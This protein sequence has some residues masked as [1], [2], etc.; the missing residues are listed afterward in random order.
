MK[1]YIL[2]VGF[3]IASQYAQAQTLK[4]IFNTYQPTSTTQANTDTPASSGG[5]QTAPLDLEPSPDPQA[6][7]EVDQTP[8]PEK[9]ATIEDMIAALS[10]DEDYLDVPNG[11]KK[12]LG[13][14]LPPIIMSSNPIYE[15]I[16]DILVAGGLGANKI[17]RWL[18]T[19]RIEGYKEFFRIHGSTSVAKG[20]E[21]GEKV[22]DFLN[23]ISDKEKL[24]KQNKVDAS[25]QA[26]TN[27]VDASTQA[28]TNKVDASTQ[29][30]TN[31]VNKRKRKKVDTNKVDASTQ[32]DTDNSEEVDTLPPD[33]DDNLISADDNSNDD[34]NNDSNNDS[35]KQKPNFSDLF[36]SAEK[37]KEEKD[38]LTDLIKKINKAKA[39]GPLLGLIPSNAKIDDINQILNNNS[40]MFKKL[41]MSIINY[42]DDKADENERSAANYNQ[43]E[44]NSAVD[45]KSLRSLLNDYFNSDY[46]ESNELEDRENY[47][48]FELQ[49]V[50]L[51][52][53]DI[54]ELFISNLRK[55]SLFS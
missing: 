17:K 26:D 34:S 3:A 9:S 50:D 28:D 2:L 4:N 48:M 49:D 35:I 47:Q 52:P 32:V 44:F 53:N 29:A 5:P 11:L 45:Y 30:N 16:R 22:D 54:K 1:K 6:K 20:L 13:N 38:N 27:K 23:R 8:Q 14:K 55:T 12:I 7:P 43:D 18:N 39:L 36:N 37:T 31:K 40:D 41:K 42:F 51:T 25:T 24:L 15:K 19:G 33:D 46:L 21:K 10:A